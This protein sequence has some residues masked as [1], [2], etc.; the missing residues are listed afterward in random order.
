MDSTEDCAVH[1]LAYGLRCKRCGRWWPDRV[2]SLEELA[3]IVRN[4]GDHDLRRQVEAFLRRA[5]VGVTI[6]A[7][8]RN[9]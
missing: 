3:S 9:P 7:D 8:T 4:V 1:L 2:Q 6:D 5:V